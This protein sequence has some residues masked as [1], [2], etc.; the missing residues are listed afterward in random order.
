MIDPVHNGLDG[1]ARAFSFRPAGPAL[2]MLLASDTAK[3]V[4]I[5]RKPPVLGFRLNSKSCFPA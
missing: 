4:E 3:P 2:C 5:M 1:R